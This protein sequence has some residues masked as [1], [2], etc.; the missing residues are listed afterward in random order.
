[1]YSTI[2]KYHTISVVTITSSLLMIVNV[3]HVHTRDCSCRG[4]WGQQ[5]AEFTV[6]LVSAPEYSLEKT[7]EDSII[8]RTVC[9]S[10]YIER[11]LEVFKDTQRSMDISR[12]INFR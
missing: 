2:S 8:C 12:Y 7:G 10:L 9:R 3:Y 4:G 6:I 5:V 11:C 1:M